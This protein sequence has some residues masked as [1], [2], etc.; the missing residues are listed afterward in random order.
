MQQSSIQAVDVIRA[1]RAEST[2]KKSSLLYGQSKVSAAKVLTQTTASEKKH[3]SH[4]DRD[5]H[6]LQ[7]CYT[8]A[9][10]LRRHKQDQKNN[11]SK[12][13]N[14]TAHPKTKAGKTSI[15]TLG[16][17]SDNNDESSD[18]DIKASAHAALLVDTVALSVRGK[19]T[20]WLIDSGCGHIMSPH[21]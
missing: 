3:C 20:N 16:D 17:K 10:I 5:G 4:C 9:G 2:R 11:K 6:T 18:D 13:G 1:L 14:S 21:K 19:S 15:V 7:E 8:A 12:S